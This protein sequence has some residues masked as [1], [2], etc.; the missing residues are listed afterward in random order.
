MLDRL[1]SRGPRDEPITPTTLLA[2]YLYRNQTTSSVDGHQIHA[3]LIAI[4]LGG[5]N[6]P[7]IEFGLDSAFGCPLRT[8]SGEV[9]LRRHSIGQGGRQP[10]QA[11]GTTSLCNANAWPDG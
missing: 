8:V 7:T 4:G 9:E 6:I 5:G 3:G 2:L 1:G 11:Q 10:G